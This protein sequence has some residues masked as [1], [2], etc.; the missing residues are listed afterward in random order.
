MA[1]QK[2]EA[3]KQTSLFSSCTGD[4]L[5]L[6]GRVTEQATLNA[7]TVIVRE[8]AIP[9][10]MAIINSGTVTVTSGDTELATLGA[11]DVVGE[12][13]MVD[14]AEASATCTVSETADVW[15][16]ARA[17]FLPV[18]QENHDIS[19]ALLHAVVARL[20]ATNELVA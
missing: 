9:H 5:E 19:T 3:L 18:W 10:Q 6:I 1:D 20:R 17:G 12:L 7:G 15:V 13:A 4:Q 14:G 16:I 8:G 2:L 11:G